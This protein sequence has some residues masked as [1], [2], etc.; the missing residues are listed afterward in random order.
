VLLVFGLAGDIEVP[1]SR[2]GRS[3]ARWWISVGVV[4]PGKVPGGGGPVGKAGPGSCWITVGGCWTVRSRGGG[5][6]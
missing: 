5:W 1:E 3:K 6:R 2:L 4:G